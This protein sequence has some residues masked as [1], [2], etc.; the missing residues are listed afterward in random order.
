MMKEGNYMGIVSP[1]IIL[2]FREAQELV[3]LG[4]DAALR[5]RLLHSYLSQQLRTCFQMTTQL[6]SADTLELS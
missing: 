4:Q 6:S 1:G 5:E 3:K 2:V